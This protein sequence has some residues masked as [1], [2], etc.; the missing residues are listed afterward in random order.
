MSLL[1]LDATINAIATNTHQ[2]RLL[3]QPGNHL[4]RALLTSAVDAQ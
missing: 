2:P 3:T 1:Q 4:T